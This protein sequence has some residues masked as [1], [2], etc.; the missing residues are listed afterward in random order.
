MYG[1][2]IA[3]TN[4]WSGSILLSWGNWRFLGMIMLFSI[5]MFLAVKVCFK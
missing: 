1:L 5:E 4:S 2:D 3:L